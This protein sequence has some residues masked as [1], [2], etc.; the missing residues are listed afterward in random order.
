[1]HVFLVIV[2]N[3]NCDRVISCPVYFNIYYTHVT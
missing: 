3:Y 1:M 2:S